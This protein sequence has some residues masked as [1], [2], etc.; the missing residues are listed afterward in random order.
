MSTAVLAQQTLK[1]RSSITPVAQKVVVPTRTVST[2]SSQR[3]EAHLAPLQAQGVDIRTYQQTTVQEF[4]VLVELMRDKSLHAKVQSGAAKVLFYDSP[5]HLEKAKQFADRHGIVPLFKFSPSDSPTGRP[6][7]WGFRP[8]IKVEGAAR[9][10]DGTLQQVACDYTKLRDPEALLMEFQ[11]TIAPQIQAFNTGQVGAVDFSQISFLAMPNGDF[12][13]A[14][15]LIQSEDARRAALNIVSPTCDARM[16]FRQL[17]VMATYGGRKVSDVMFEPL[18]E[19]GRNN[20]PLFRIRFSTAKKCEVVPMVLDK[21]GYDKLIQLLE[22]WG[23]NT[24][25]MAKDKGPNKTVDSAIRLTNPQL[26][27]NFEIDPDPSS[28]KMDGV[29]DKAVGV[30][31]PAY[32]RGLS[33]RM[34]RVPTEQGKS[35]TLRIQ[36]PGRFAHMKEIGFTPMQ[37][38][39]LQKIIQEPNGL[40]LMTGPTGEG[41][42]TT[43]YSFLAQLNK[44]ERKIITVEDPVEMHLA[45]IVQI[46]LSDDLDFQAA[47]RACLRQNPNIILIGEV[48]DSITADTVIQA[49]A[50]GHLIFSTLHTNSAAETIGRLATLG[51]KPHD[52]AQSFLCAMAQRL[53]PRLSQRFFVENESGWKIDANYFDEFDAVEELSMMFKHRFTGECT[54]VRPKP[55]SQVPDP[56]FT[57]Y[58]NSVAAV[59]E[60]L[61]VDAG[62][63]DLIASQ[64]G[65]QEILR[66]AMTREGV[67]RF[68]PM[69]IHGLLLAMNGDVLLD[70][71]KMKFGAEWFEGNELNRKLAITMI[72]FQLDHPEASFDEVMYG[73]PFD[74]D[75]EILERPIV[76]ISEEEPSLARAHT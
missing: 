42:T 50:T 11:Q 52:S 21:A 3:L 60:I 61:R 64:S 22:T 37:Q 16:V 43:L 19:V 36:Y 71:W 58:D 59:L 69:Q 73:A 49:C 54:L 7:V 63:K 5:Y 41:K 68:V 46:K 23:E 75:A 26:G 31:Y 44:P 8:E 20:D 27:I 34:N 66:H 14:L 32:M 17:M 62:M 57:A 65:Q 56:N 15:N 48:R 53:I 13:K 29:V 47:Q 9:A 39:M 35:I 30:P 67:G 1:D 40:I 76:D 70:D 6:M 38:E 72:Q 33:F 55:V 24:G 25:G 18:G 51:V 2:V 28:L 45:G 12:D 4:D 10:A 74:P